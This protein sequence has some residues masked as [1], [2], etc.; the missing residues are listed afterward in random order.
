MP[1]QADTRTIRVA[2]RMDEAERRMASTVAKHEGLNLSDWV[3]LQV[4]HRYNELRPVRKP[5][6]LEARRPPP[7]AGRSTRPR[8]AQ[9]R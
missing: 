9:C 7:G 1:R 2:I 5:A 6:T 3:R 4:R 8:G